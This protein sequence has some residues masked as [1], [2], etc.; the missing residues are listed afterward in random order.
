MAK[1][2]KKR[3]KKYTGPDAKS[4]QPNV[5][6]VTAVRRSPLGQWWHEKKKVVKIA[7]IAAAVVIFIIWLLWTL[8]ALIFSW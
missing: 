8:L 3:N 1:Q 2:K 7:S 5:I 6:R 4:T